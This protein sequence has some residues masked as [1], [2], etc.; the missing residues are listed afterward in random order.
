MSPDGNGNG[1]L[2]VYL[3][4]HLAGSE[5]ALELLERIGEASEGELRATLASLYAEIEADQ[6]LLRAL[7]SR[8]DGG[9]RSVRRALG[10]L[11]EK[12]TRLKLAPGDGAFA[13]FE[14]LE[15][16]LLGIEGKRCL[17]RVLARLTDADP[18]L[19][20]LDFLSLLRRADAQHA[21]VERLRL[22]AARTALLEP[23]EVARP[24]REEMS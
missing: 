17:W 18:I 6:R 2:H 3:A 19:A 11:A 21:E 9:Q 20:E 13:R 7:V 4:D 24:T 16:L 10:W 15:L 12:V 5:L 22:D 23:E 1:S 8:I 14:S